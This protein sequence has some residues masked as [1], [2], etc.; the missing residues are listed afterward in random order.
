MRKG[1]GRSS[2]KVNRETELLNTA[3]V[4]AVREGRL[5]RRP[6]IRSLPEPKARRGFFEKDEYERIVAELPR[7]VDDIARFA[8]I[9]GW[10]R[11]EIRTLKWENV[12]RENREV[13][14]YNSKNGEG[15]ALA[16]DEEAWK[17]FDKLW[18]QRRYTR[19]DGTESD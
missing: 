15:R 8:Y 14:L 17:L 1:K 9:C 2:A 6:Y 19:H 18:E 4:F 10:R 7:P 16:L 3:Y 11:E 5:Q 13:R 12:D